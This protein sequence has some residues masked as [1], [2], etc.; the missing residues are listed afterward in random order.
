MRNDT[1]MQVRANNLL[2]LHV[3]YQLLL[4]LIN[5]L[6]SNPDQ[7]NPHI[8]IQGKASGQPA[9]RSIMDQVQS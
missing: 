3:F 2:Q 9:L 5:S 8:Y 1:Q 7:K 4:F 6:L